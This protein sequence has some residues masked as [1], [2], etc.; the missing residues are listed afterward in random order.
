MSRMRKFFGLFATTVIVAACYDLFARLAPA[1]GSPSICMTHAFSPP[2]DKHSVKKHSIRWTFTTTLLFQY[3]VVTWFAC[4][5][6]VL[7]C[8]SAR[9]A[10]RRLSSR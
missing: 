9:A 2:W 5:G 1:Y 8:I 6:R 10:T 4:R 3:P 7:S